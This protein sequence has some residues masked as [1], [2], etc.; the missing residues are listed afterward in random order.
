VN[1][2]MLVTNLTARTVSPRVKEVIVKA[3]SA[4]LKLEVVDTESR[5]H[6]TDLA[7]DAADRGFDLVIAFG[8][9]GTMNE[10]ANGIAGTETAMAVLP[11]GMANVMCRTIG[12]PVDIVE[13]TGHLLNRVKDAE[14]RRINIGKMDGRYFVLSCGI[15]L[16]AETVKRVEADP[17]KKRKY[18]DWFFVYCAL[19][20]FFSSYR[21]REALFHLEADGIS[22]EFM[23]VI[24]SNTPQ[25][26]YFKNRPVILMPEATLDG[27]LDA[28][29]VR[30]LPT[31]WIPALAAGLLKTGRHIKKKYVRYMKGLESMRFES[32]GPALPIQLD[33]EYL[34]ERREVEVE[35]VR[36]GLSILS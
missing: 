20:A 17:V 4:D 13:A 33:G 10:V 8:G 15:G 23:T 21:G 2:A 30:K 19:R 1:Q 3:L 7:R 12:V 32:L 28:L 36:D 14:T 29:G 34:G 9:D 16:D 22:D 26:T 24:V 11:G 6:A 35:L 27:E 31:S 5:N 25:F 18:R